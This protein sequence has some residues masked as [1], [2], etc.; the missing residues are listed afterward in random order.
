MRN[1]NSGRKGRKR[2][3]FSDGSEQVMVEVLLSSVQPGSKSCHRSLEWSSLVNERR[4]ALKVGQGKRAL[5]DWL[6]RWDSLRPAIAVR[7]IE[8]VWSMGPPKNCMLIRKG[9]MEFGTYFVY[10][11]TLLIQLN[12]LSWSSRST[13][14][15]HE[16]IS[17]PATLGT[18][19]ENAN[20]ATIG[21]PCVETCQSTPARPHP[22]L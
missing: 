5:I 11:E 13:S 3:P 19:C 9:K 12:M 18:K 15:D 2:S 4:R 7:L 10:K 6:T 14:A 8:N 20:R 1:A 16:A 22:R 17:R 21:A